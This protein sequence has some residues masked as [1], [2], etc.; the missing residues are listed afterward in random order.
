[1]RLIGITGGIGT[2]KSTVT[3]YLHSRYHLPILDADIYAR[4]AVAVGSPILTAIGQR[5]GDDILRS[6]GTLD[7][8]QLGE[9]IFN[10]PVERQWLESQIHPYVR[11]CFDREISRL[12]PDATAVLAIP[13]L[14]EAKITDLVTEIWVVSCDL[15]TQIER[16]M[17]RDLIDKT[18]AIKRIESQM[19][20]A[21]KMA[22]ADV[23]LDN[24]TNITDLERQ[25]DLKI[26][27]SI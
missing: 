13:L 27:N 22:L 25:I 2:G 15:S 17:Q 16:V 14:F 8:P 11:H 1:M 9:I 10:N 7:R 20:L 21:E 19:P 24:S 18:A 23:N 12:Q 4:A 3:N 6:D 5:Y 26:S